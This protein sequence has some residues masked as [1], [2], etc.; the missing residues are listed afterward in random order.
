MSAV[1]AFHVG[2]RLAPNSR[3]ADALR[4]LAPTPAGYGWFRAKARLPGRGRGCQPGCSRLVTLEIQANP[5]GYQP[6]PGFVGHDEVRRNDGRALADSAAIW[7]EGAAPW[8]APARPCGNPGERN[9]GPSHRHRRLRPHLRGEDGQ[10]RRF[11]NFYVN[12]EDIRFLGNEKYSFQDGDEV[13]VI[14]SIAGGSW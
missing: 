9:P 11:I 4:R 12:E 10:I 5:P 8:Q 7:R 6:S 1:I 14:P 13:L 2:H 3:E